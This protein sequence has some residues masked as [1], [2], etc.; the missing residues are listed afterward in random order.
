LAEALGPV[1]AAHSATRNSDE[2]S[3]NNYQIDQNECYPVESNKCLGKIHT[4]K[5]IIRILAE[6]NSK[7]LSITI[8]GCGWLGL[9]LGEELVNRGYKVWGSVRSKDTFEQLRQA[10]I[11][12]FSLDLKESTSI[13]NELSNSTETLIISIPPLYRDEPEKFQQILNQVLSQFSNKVLVIFTSSTGIYPKE[14]G[15]FN[16]NFEFNSTQ[17]SSVLN[18]AEETI[19][20]SKKEHAIFRFGGLIG[21][22]RHPIRFLEGRKNVKN[23]RGPINFVHQGDCIRALVEAVTN[24]AL[25]GTFNLV[26]PHHPERKNYYEAAAKYYDLDPPTFKDETPRE[27][28]ISSKKII[29]ECAFQFEYPINQFPQLHLD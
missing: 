20:N 17:E 4:A 28:I 2:T 25:R 24:E 3:G 1:W 7:N 12:P 13:P 8:I 10:G 18:T 16:E 11:S 9:P 29:Q 19:R 26:F 23:P 15:N 21:P 22:N 6:V 14:T 27:R 5:L